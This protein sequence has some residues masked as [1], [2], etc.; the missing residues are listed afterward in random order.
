MKKILII[1]YGFIGSN[2]Y[3]YLI[4]KNYNVIVASPSVY[5]SYGDNFYQISLEQLCNNEKI[6]TGVTE[7]V[8]LAHIAIPSSPLTSF[9]IEFRQI[10]SPSKILFR[11]L[12]EKNINL[13]YV[14][15]GGSI[16]GRSA[17]MYID[18]TCQTIPI[19]LY[20]ITKLLIERL[21]AAINIEKSLRYIILRPSNIYGYH[22]IVKK[23]GIVNIAIDA[24]LN[25]KSINI[26]G[27]GF[28]M[29]DYMYIDDFV[30][31]LELV[32]SAEES[33]PNDIFNVGSSKYYS[34]NEVINEVENIFAKKIVR[35]YISSS[36]FNEKYNFM[37]IN[38]LQEGINNIFNKI[39]L[40]ENA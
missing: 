37:A 31:A 26:W 9:D 16:Y 11:N 13:V 23:Q 21:I 25:G 38:D 4:N 1:G 40:D 24:V 8:F 3:E 35:N 19:S 28:G 15:S 17:A 6:L 5:K 29:K 2:L 33:F 18:E 12:A 32:L 22:K 14:S 36:K 20:G 7:V 34:V 27:D 39:S 30:R 10:I